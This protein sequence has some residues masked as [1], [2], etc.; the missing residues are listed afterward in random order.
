MESNIKGQYFRVSKW[1][2]LNSSIHLPGVKQVTA[3]GSD[4]TVI[5]KKTAREKTSHGTTI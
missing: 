5:A 1:P 4:V 2:L 3:D